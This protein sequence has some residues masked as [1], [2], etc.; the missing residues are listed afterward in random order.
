MRRDPL[1]ILLAVSLLALGSGSATA[2]V[3]EQEFELPLSVALTQ[4]KGNG[5]VDFD[6]ESDDHC[7][8]GEHC[9]IYALS[10]CIQ[11]YTIE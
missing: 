6:C 4:D 11:G 3:T 2:A 5:Y 1:A 10:D 9:E 8:A 7:D